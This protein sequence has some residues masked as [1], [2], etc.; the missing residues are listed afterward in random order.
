[1]NTFS[2]Y[3]ENFFTYG[4]GKLGESEHLIKYL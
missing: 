3:N 2:I 4:L 1:M